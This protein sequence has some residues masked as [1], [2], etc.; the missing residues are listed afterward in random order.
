M[1]MVPQFGQLGYQLALEPD[2]KNI[3]TATAML[4][5]AYV[6]SWTIHL[7]ETLPILLDGY[8]AGLETGN[9]EFMGYDA[10]LYCFNA[11]W[12]GQPL[13]EL[14]PQIRAYYQQL[15]DLHQVTAANCVSASTCRRSQILLGQSEEEIPLTPG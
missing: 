11:Y 3:R 1:T 7:Q 2:A 9:L 6:G 4:M 8:Q 5:G 13:A 15:G 10:Q 12:Y 14:E